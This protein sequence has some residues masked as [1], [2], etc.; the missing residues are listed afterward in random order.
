MLVCHVETIHLTRRNEMKFNYT[1]INFGHFV[2]FIVPINFLHP[3]AE[4]FSLWTNS[5]F[6]QNFLKCLR[7][8][9][10]KNLQ[11]ML[12]IDEIFSIFLNSFPLHHQFFEPLQVLLLKFREIS[13]IF[14]FHQSKK[15][16]LPPLCLIKC[17]HTFDGKIM[18]KIEA[19]NR[20]EGE[21][22]AIEWVE[23]EKIESEMLEHSITLHRR[24]MS[25]PDSFSQWCRNESLMNL[26]IREIYRVRISF[27][28]LN[29]Y[30]ILEESLKF[31]ASR[32]NL[33]LT[34]LFLPPSFHRRWSEYS[35]FPSLSS[36]RTFVQLTKIDYE[37]CTIFRACKVWDNR[38]GDNFD[39]V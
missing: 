11:M 23:W 27:P 3:Q 20:I 1:T 17:Q 35:I 4:F 6:H 22:R 28:H 36:V 5:R 31:P 16:M 21:H 38:A 33:I 13:H 8:L 30:E 15:A 2:E 7:N 34:F 19:E 18:W 14:L 10:K 9:G 25:F 29:F 37:I 24:V 39:V 12:E 32:F 26:F